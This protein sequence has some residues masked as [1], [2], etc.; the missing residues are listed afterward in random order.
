MRERNTVRHTFAVAGVLIGLFAAPT[1]ALAQSEGIALN[2]YSPAERGSDWFMTDSLDFRG[3][4]RVQAGITTDWAQDPL[5]VY[6]RDGGEAAAI[7]RTQPFAHLGVSWL[8]SDRLRFGLNVPVLLFTSGES[9]QTQGG[10]FEAPAGAAMGDVRL[11]V[12]TGL[13][14]E[15]REPFSLGVG[16]QVHL[17]TGSRDKYTSDGATRLVPRVNAAGDVGS[18]TY[19]AQLAANIR[20]THSEFVGS[21]VD[22]EL[23]LGASGGVRLLQSPRASRYPVHRVSTT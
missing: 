1:T 5:V 17:P 21:K 18:F 2:R 22:Q 10:T 19:A 14:G 9:Q 4:R 8:H 20:T 15:Y 13:V 7:V 3:E 23:M 16:L 11:S 12:D 6:D